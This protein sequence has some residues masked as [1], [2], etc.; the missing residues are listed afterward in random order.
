MNNFKSIKEMIQILYIFFFRTLTFSDCSSGGDQTQLLMSTK[1][2]LSS[3]ILF[4]FDLI[5]FIK[6]KTR[7]L[8]LL[9]SLDNGLTMDY[10]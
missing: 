10:C 8:V 1:V 3:P 7:L 5:E 9:I 4:C 6:M 2:F